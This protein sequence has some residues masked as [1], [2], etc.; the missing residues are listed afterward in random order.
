MID[1]KIS[2]NLEQQNDEQNEQKYNSEGIQTNRTDTVN[3][4]RNTGQTYQSNNN[5]KIENLS[6]NGILISEQNQ[7]DKT[8]DIQYNLVY[9]S[10]EQNN[11]HQLLNDDDNEEDEQNDD[12]SLS[13]G[14][15]QKLESIDLKVQ[16]NKYS[17]VKQF[18]LEQS[19]N[20]KDNNQNV[21]FN[22][23]QKGLLDTLD[24][25]PDQFMNQKSK[26][27]KQQDKRDQFFFSEKQRAKKK[28]AV[29]DLQNNKISEN[30]DNDNDINDQRQCQQKKKEKQQGLGKQQKQTYINNGC[31]SGSNS[32]NNLLQKQSLLSLSS[33]NKPTVTKVFQSIVPAKT[34]NNQILEI[35]VYYRY[36]GNMGD[37]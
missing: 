31:I 6:K 2:A 3:L 15:K 21:Q 32:N 16:K 29:F 34:N 27:I 14:M 19:Q 33:R 22:K 25:S 30:N 18:Q 11:Q 23:K 36:F 24:Q 4:L 37:C 5:D 35:R 1:N 8:Y 9:S 28:R 26:N 13:E 12:S 20:P 7:I 17:L 10:S